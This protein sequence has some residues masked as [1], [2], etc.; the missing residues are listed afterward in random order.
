LR[1]YRR[2]CTDLFFID[3]QI[4]DDYLIELKG[5]NIEVFDTG[6]VLIGIVVI[7]GVFCHGRF[8]KAGSLPLYL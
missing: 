6:I 3:Y 7:G 1:S 5:Q 8:F 4:F 2:D